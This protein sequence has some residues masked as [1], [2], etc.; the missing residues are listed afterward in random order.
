M[1]PADS[2]TPAK[3]K[4]VRA[5]GPRLRVLLSICLGLFAALG[6]NSVYLS[7]ITFLEWSTKQVYQNYFYQIMFLA[8]LALGLLL[9]VP[10][11]I[12]GIGHIINSHDRPNR[13]AVRVGYVLF[14]VTLILLITGIALTR[15][16][17]FKLVGTARTLSY[18]AHVIT[19][20]LAVWLFVLHRLAGPRIQWKLGL[21]WA[22]AVAVVVG[23]MVLLHKQDPRQWNVAGPKEGAQYFEPSMART[24]SGNFIPAKTLMMDDYCLKCHKDSYQGWFHSS[25]H[26]SSF[27]NPP[28]L[29]SVRE[30][31]KVSL[32][33]DGSV[34]A[35]RWCAG[36]HDLVPFFSGAFDDPNFDDVRHPTSQAGITCT[37]CHAITHV[38]STIGNADYTIDEPIH[39]PFAFSTNSILQFVNQQM[40]KAKPEFHKK[41]FL[42]PLHKTAEFCSTCHKVSIPYALNHYKEWLRGQNHYDSFL[43]SG[44]SGH[45]ARSFYYPPTAKENCAS[46]HMP[47]QPSEDF[48][49]KMFSGT[50]VASIH[51]H[52]FPAAN[53]ALPHL[54]GDLAS[55]KRQQEFLKGCARIDIFGLK[56]GGTIDSPLIAP[57]RPE[58]PQL[59]RGQKYLIEAVVRTLKLG[60]PLTQGTVDSNELWV[61]AKITSQ[62]RVIGRNG[63]LGPYNTVDPWSHFLNVYML[64]KEGNRI[65]RRNP[66]DIFTPLYNHQV[67]PGAAAVVHY[68][69]LVPEDIQG[70]ITVHL[71]LQY[72]KFDTTYMQYVSGKTY[73]NDLPITTIGEDT[74]SFAVEGTT[75]VPNNEPSKVD[76]WQRWNDYGIGLLLEGDKGSEKGELIQAAQ[77]F[78]QVEMLKKADGPLNLARVYF[79]E[80]R[81]ED[82]VIA[83]Q[84]ASKFDPPAPRWTVAW[85]NGLVNKQNGYLDQ[86]I[87]EF[88]SILEDKYPEIETRG[89]DFSKDYEVINELGQTLFERSKQARSNPDQQRELVAG[90]IEQFKKTLALDSENLAAHYNLSLLYRNIAD[91]TKAEYHQAQH[92]KYRPDDNAR[93]RAIANARRANPAADNAA[94]SIVIYPLNRPGAFELP[95]PPVL[96]TAAP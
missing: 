61:D 95:A 87:K 72:R 40:V 30:T 68:A 53:T 86:A 55:V 20:L 35:A 69:L 36:C 42:K 54:R 83:L 57:L 27:N 13:R 62:G 2:P 74:L 90:A 15:I 81:L 18:W 8:H 12:F 39:Y 33:R 50:N 89:F 88:R 67:G 22:G 16:G 26:F 34:K 85:L 73:T 19:P 17:S 52:F 78:T 70:P 32:E 23:A 4:Y 25:H 96:Q 38:N 37:A 80:G 63:G 29:F 82:A 7:S 6:A 64:D 10:T 71:K 21:S 51:D 60:H 49:A 93:D 31:R 3:R 28:Y 48:G 46:C 1:I 94:Q 45:S 84:R 65:D 58:V 79:K 77:A 75:T 44:V 5:V 24:A 76:L 92:E 41:T 9:V 43:L 47:L 66:Q 59:K 14:A 56:V 91:K 11:I